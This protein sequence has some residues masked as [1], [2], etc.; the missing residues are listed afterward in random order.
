[1]VALPP[2]VLR[3]VSR[4]LLPLEH[5]LP[6]DV[7][8]P[9]ND[10]ATAICPR[11]LAIERQQRSVIV[12]R[13]IAAR[14]LGDAALE[15]PI[16]RL[17]ITSARGLAAAHE[18]IVDDAARAAE[19]RVITIVGVD[20]AMPARGADT[21]PGGN[22]EEESHE[23]QDV[24]GTDLARFCE[25]VAAC[26]GLRTLIVG[27]TLGQPW[28]GSDHGEP[29]QLSCRIFRVPPT[30]V[31]ITADAQSEQ[32]I[33]EIFFAPALKRLAMA[34]GEEDWSFA[35]W[36]ERDGEMAKSSLPRLDALYSG[37]C[38][39]QHDLWEVHACSG[40]WDVHP[41]L[42]QYRVY[43]T[44][45][46]DTRLHELLTD[47]WDEVET[48]LAAASGLALRH[49]IARGLPDEFSREVKWRPS[50]ET[51]EI[52]VPADSKGPEQLKMVADLVEMVEWFAYGGDEYEVHG[53][54]GIVDIYDEGYNREMSGGGGGR[55][56]MA[57]PDDEH[58]YHGPKR[59]FPH[60]LRALT[61]FSHAADLPLDKHLDELAKLCKVGKI[62]F[63]REVWP[64]AS[65]CASM[66][67]RA[68]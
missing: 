40:A 67:M 18:M 34:D 1:M 13:R 37:W 3:L 33:R 59:L 12:G 47:E 56:Y 49:L 51:I 10:A 2:D 66:I 24:V 62:A 5:E 26:R 61:I 68:G 16:R 35:S 65:Q 6:D 27:C 53:P 11:Y 25:L 20:L 60:R 17:F 58:A 41:N 39:I 14:L 4:N 21:E 63:S 55:A 9:L 32:A 44:T 57:D 7:Y 19:M 8:V 22:D 43:D 15:A 52:R 42:E 48:A 54:L 23:C 38:S 36:Y 29:I 46:A 50:L 30:V 64:S 28:C 31:S 45:Y